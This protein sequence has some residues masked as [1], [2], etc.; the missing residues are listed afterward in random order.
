MKRLLLICSAFVASSAWAGGVQP[1]KT[2]TWKT[3]DGVE[4]VGA[5]Q[6]S[7]GARARTWIC[8]HGLGSVQGEWFYVMPKIVALGDGVLTY[9]ARGHGQSRK[10]ERGPLDYQSFDA[11]QWR[12][13]V[14]DVGSAVQFLKQQGVPPERIA[15]AGA[16]LGANVALNYAGE[17][18]EVPALV[19]LSPGLNYAGIETP[20]AWQRYGKR[21]VFIAASP[22]DRYAFESVRRLISTRGDPA[23]RVV[24]GPGVQHGV[25][26]LDDSVTAKLL[27]WIK[28]LN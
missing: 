25:N 11:A 22:G 28:Q 16:S 7:R 13:M 9:D 21:P 20:D 12:Q 15:L 1:G 14:A 6:P 18:R 4:L 23:C 2:V 19:L 5:Y 8:L 17:H 10:S 26:M 27:S 3:P 24:E